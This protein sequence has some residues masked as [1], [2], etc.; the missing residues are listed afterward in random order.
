MTQQTLAGEKAPT[1]AEIE[2]EIAAARERLAGNIADLINQVHPRAIVHNTVADARQ[3]VSGEF[4][5]LKDQ[6]VDDDGVRVK[7]VG[8][9][10][11]AVAG[12][13]TFALIV[14]SIV[15]SR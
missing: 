2:A 7:R 5:Q 10:V 14:R 8:L 3:F 12:A 6:F 9:V 1:R 15:T 11:A 13:A 4:R